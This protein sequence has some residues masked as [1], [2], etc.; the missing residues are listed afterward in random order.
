MGGWCS[1]N[2]QALYLLEHRH[3]PHSR[4]VQVMIIGETA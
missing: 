3:A 2:W 1:V 4:T